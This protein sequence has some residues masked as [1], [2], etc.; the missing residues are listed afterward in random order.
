MSGKPRTG[1]GTFGT[2]STT[3]LPSGAVQ[4]TT[5][6]R[7]WDGRL[8]RVTATAATRAKAEAALRAKLVERDRFADTGEAVTPDTEFSKLA[9]LWLEEIEI[10]P[11]LAYGTKALYATELRTLLLPT[12]EHLTVREI[13]TGRLER[14]LKVQA[15]ASYS[16]AKH[17]RVLLNL[18]MKFAMRHGALGHNPLAGT[19]P[20]HKPRVAPK[21][22]TMDELAR[23]RTAVR[24]LRTGESLPGPKPDGQLRDII[25][26]MLGTSARIGEALALR[27]C[28]VDMTA[29]PPI[30]H[31]RGTVV[32][33]TGTGVVRQDWPKTH[34]SD[35]IVAIPQ[36]AAEVIRRRL[37][38][39]AEGDPKHLLFFT[40]RGTPITPYN[41][42]RTFRQVLELAGLAGHG[43]K[44]HS[45]RKT[46]ATLISEELDD[47]TAA[48]MLGHSGTAVTREHYIERKQKPNP[49]T[50]RILDRLAPDSSSKSAARPSGP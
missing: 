14:F 15:A 9:A 3:V 30:V 23:I 10:D 2:I 32:V 50:A 41:A 11:R 18:I 16:K 26:V 37:A 29:N 8:R 24:D 42:R 4:A 36:F 45:F 39:T 33:R 44:P 48:E 40:K 31:I 22:L 21:G 20:L 34:T 19:S 47:E 38:L 25:E 46:I 35:R 17:S 7:D 13:T 12:W 28:D 27:K 5:R 6:F 49:E 43:I 1:I